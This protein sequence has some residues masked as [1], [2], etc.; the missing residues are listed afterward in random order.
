MAK[1]PRIPEKYSSAGYSD[2]GIKRTLREAKNVARWSP[3]HAH[4]WMEEARNY[5][6][7]DNPYYEEFNEAVYI[8]NSYWLSMRNYRWFD[9]LTFW[10]LDGEPN[11]V[12]LIEPI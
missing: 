1:K 6:S 2:W 12:T 7:L 11:P 8:I 3:W 9:E 4:Q 10:S 5:I